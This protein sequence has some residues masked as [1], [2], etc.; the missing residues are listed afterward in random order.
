MNWKHCVAEHKLLV[1]DVTVKE[2]PVQAPGCNAPLIHLLIS[3][4]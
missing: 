2:G 4:L 1:G 3:A